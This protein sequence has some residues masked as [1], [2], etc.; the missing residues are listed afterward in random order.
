M[1]ILIVGGVAVWLTQRGGDDGGS[2]AAPAPNV[3]QAGGE[4]T[5]QAKE[6]TDALIGKGLECSVRF[7]IAAGGNA[8]CFSWADKGTTSAEVLFQYDSGGT[9]IGLNL[10]TF[11]Q[12][13][14]VAFVTLAPV[15]RTVSEVVFGADQDKVARAVAE[16]PTTDDATFDGAWGKYHVR[17]GASGTTVSAAKS[18]KY[19]LTVP[20]IEM[21]S[22]PAKLADAL[23]A[24]GFTCDAAREDCSGS[25][26]D[27]KGRTSVLSAGL[28]SG[29]IS[30]L[31]IGA[32]DTSR[33]A[34]AETTKET[35]AELVGNTLGTAGG[36]GLS[37][38]QK[39]SADHLDG[40][41]HSAYVGGWRVDLVVKYGTAYGD[42]ELA[43]S[44]GLTVSTDSLWTVPGQ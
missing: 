10:K 42:A 43:S 11:S 24:K 9:V 15:L 25:F 8:G 6:L 2:A 30:T 14:G 27:G 32:A 44:F 35:F 28:G 3:A 37:D 39:W 20:R 23:T 18:G 21:A 26:R 36:N 29:G 38:V 1:L 16:L 12:K 40:Q 5:G 41:S 13:E 17:E 4:T 33:D 22:S 31:I 19:P 34:D 7:T